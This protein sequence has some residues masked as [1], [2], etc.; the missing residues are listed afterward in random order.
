MQRKINKFEMYR[1]GCEFSDCADFCLNTP[2]SQAYNIFYVTPA[3]VNA[4]FAW[5]LF[6]KLLLNLTQIEYNRVHKLKDL[7]DVLPDNIRE[8]IKTATIE[9]YGQWK[10]SW[11]IE[12]LDNI[13]NAFNDWRYN[14]EHDW[15]KSAMMKIELEF[16]FAFKDALKEQFKDCSFYEVI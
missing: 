3:T 1:T 11:N 9:K 15:S 4:A 2:N 13:S 5:E 6:L 10:N 7:F 14:Y 16:L 12:I 8:N